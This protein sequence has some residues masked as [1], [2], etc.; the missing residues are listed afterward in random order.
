MITTVRTLL[1]IA[2]AALLSGCAG[3]VW[4]ETWQQEADR[5][6]AALGAN[7]VKVV[8]Q[9][10]TK[11]YAHC[12]GPID[13]GTD[14]HDTEWLLAHE[15]GHYLKRHCGDDPSLHDEMEANA[16][17]IKVLQVWG[18]SEQ[19]AVRHT[20]NQLRFL[21]MRGTS[22]GPGHDY[23]AELAAIQQLYPQYR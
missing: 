19:E 22:P 8:L 13:L 14:G 9:S 18:E 16:M 1:F 12:H 10:G 2:I 21:I 17:A 4:F 3:L 20:E 7:P 23:A 11:G 6:T 5:A 15:M